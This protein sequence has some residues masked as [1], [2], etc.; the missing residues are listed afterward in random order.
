MYR[1]LLK[2]FQL[3]LGLV[4]FAGIWL[5]F[6]LFVAAD[7]P[8]PLDTSF[9]GTGIVTASVTS[10][11]NFGEAIAIQGNRIIV[12]GRSWQDDHYNFTLIAYDS[13]GHLDTSFGSSGII[14]SPAGSGMGVRK[15][16]LIQPDNKIVVAGDMGQIGK[17][18]IAVVRYTS[19]GELDPSFNSTGIVTTSVVTNNYSGDIAIQPDNKIVLAGY[20]Y[21]GSDTWKSVLIRYH[22]NGSLD[23]TF[24]MAGVVTTPLRLAL[25]VAIQADDKIVISGITD[26]FQLALA[27][28]DTYGQ[29]DSTFGGTGVV[30]LSGGS[31]GN[32]LILDSNYKIVVTG[33]SGNNMLLAR[34]NS[35]GTLDPDFGSGG[36]VTTSIGKVAEGGAT[37]IQLNGKIVVVGYSSDNNSRNN[38]TTVR[39]LANG[40]LDTNFGVTGVVTTPIGNNN[41][42]SMGKDVTLQNDGKI[43]VAGY[44][45]ADD[46]FSNFVVARYNGDAPVLGINQAANYQWVE[47]GQ[48]VTFTVAVSNSGVSDA[49]DVVI[50]DNLDS[51]INFVSADQGGLYNSGVVTWQAG[52]IPMGHTITRTFAVTIGNV[53]SG[54]LLS[55]QA[56]VMSAQGITASH[57]AQIKTF[58][59]PIPEIEVV[60]GA[61][62]IAD[63]N[64]KIEFG[65]TVVGHP[66]SK[67]FIVSNM[68]EAAL[69]LTEPITVPTG[70]SIVSSFGDTTLASSQQT[71]FT[72]Q[73]DAT[74]VGIYTG[75]LVFANNDSDENP[76]NFAIDGAVQALSKNIYLPTILK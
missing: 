5:S 50:T 51:G 38:L 9:N 33:K 42:S 25:A 27:R 21:D 53:V 18:D 66:I 59:Q 24:G 72:I 46:T 34:Y 31:G 76:F 7:S 10:D 71:T 44:Y 35:N 14:T 37:K 26:N 57:T 75:D 45:Y 8:G 13:N 40:G 69:T 56:Q 62:N 17:I 49:T 41:N 19:S 60:E 6:T 12:A 36:I 2:S 3:S 43:V 68:G 20:T 67:T 48:L 74:S 63:D 47:P 22:D 4:L 55:T 29:I 58:R 28:Y 32:D 23:Q 61:L 1:N 73:L 54:T 39:Y 65:T 52:E 11:H 16:I 15:S 70:F 64:S 30:T